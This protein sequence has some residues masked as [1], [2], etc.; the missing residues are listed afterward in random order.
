MRTLCGGFTCEGFFFFGRHV[1]V[2]VVVVSLTLSVRSLKERNR[3]LWEYSVVDGNI[4]ERGVGEERTVSV[5][6]KARPPR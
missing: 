6:Y 4:A 5:Q 3:K 1:G 2:V